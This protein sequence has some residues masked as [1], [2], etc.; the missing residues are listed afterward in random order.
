V[1]GGGAEHA[2]QRQV[3]VALAL[4][5]AVSPGDPVLLEQVLH[6]VI[7]NAIRYNH[8]GGWVEVHTEQTVTG[9]EVVVTNTGAIIS[10]HEVPLLFEPFRRLN[11]RVGSAGG[12]GLGL[13][14]VRAVARAHGG[15]A[16]AFPRPGGGLAVR[17]TL[18]ANL[19]RR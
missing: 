15:D 4:G 12:S 18:P 5:Q 3:R 7:D 11:D 13:S 2:E 17:V 19:R 16:A 9:V 6:N 8:E 10:A 1:A 14:I